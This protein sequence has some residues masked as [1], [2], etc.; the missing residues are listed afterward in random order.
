VQLHDFRGSLIKIRY[1]R[2][3]GAPSPGM[4]AGGER[5]Y[6]CHMAQEHNDLEISRLYLNVAIECFNKAALEELADSAEVF[7]P[8]YSPQITEMSDGCSGKPQFDS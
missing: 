8:S 4:W 2:A 6:R 7:S 3:I 5:H 1:L